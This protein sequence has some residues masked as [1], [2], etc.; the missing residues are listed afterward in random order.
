RRR[1]EGGGG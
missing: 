1:G